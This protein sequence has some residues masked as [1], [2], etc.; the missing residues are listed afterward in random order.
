MERAAKPLK[1]GEPQ[2]QIAPESC[3]VSGLFPEVSPYILF[4]IEIEMSGF[5]GQIVWNGEG[6]RNPETI[7]CPPNNITVCRRNWNA[8]VIATGS[9]F[10]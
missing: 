10:S 2:N 6:D 8:G 7:F 5:S 9:I 1:H 3:P 4:I